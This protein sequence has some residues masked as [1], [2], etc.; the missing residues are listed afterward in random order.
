VPAPPVV[1]VDPPPLVPQAAIV[2]APIKVMPRRA[3]RE[4][5]RASMMEGYSLSKSGGNHGDDRAP[6]R[7][8]ESVDP[9]P[10]DDPPPPV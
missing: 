7:Y 10:P 4:E 5:G 6:H 1:V 2:A 8:Q 9:P 3:P